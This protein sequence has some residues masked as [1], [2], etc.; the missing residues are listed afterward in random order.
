MSPVILRM[1]SPP[2]ACAVA[3]R[4]LMLLVLIN[5]SVWGTLGK[6]I[7][8]ATCIRACYVALLSIPALSVNVTTVEDRLTGIIHAFCI[9]TEV[10]GIE[11]NIQSTDVNHEVSAEMVQMF[12]N[13]IVTVAEGIT[14]YSIVR[15]SVAN[16]RLYF[17]NSTLQVTPAFTP[18]GFIE[19]MC[20]SQVGLNTVQGSA[21]IFRSRDG[22]SSPEEGECY[23]ISCIPGHTI[24]H[25]NC[26]CIIYHSSFS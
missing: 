23:F 20:T 7:G 8:R 16:D 18:V 5:S 13:E 10:E 22:E 4:W 24:I 6:G 17:I 14:M 15:G 19:F 9:A 25:T 26:T 2:I 11:W 3:A 1:L 12:A 21:T